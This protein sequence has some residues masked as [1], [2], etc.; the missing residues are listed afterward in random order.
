MK[1]LLIAL[2]CLTLSSVLLASC[3]SGEEHV[4]TFTDEWRYDASGHWHT[5]TCE[6]ADEVSD[7]GAHVDS[8]GNDICDVC[9]YIADHTHTFETAWTQGEDTHYYKSACGHNVKKD[10]AKHKDADNDGDCDVCAYNGGHEH[11]FEEGWTGLEDG[12]WH[13]PACGHT[14]DGIGKEAHADEDNDGAC[15]I[16]AYNGGH[17]HTYAEEFTTTSDEHWREVTCG[18]SIPVGDKGVHADSDGDTACDVCGYIPEH[19]HTFEETW[20]ADANGH[21]HKAT[22]E[23]IDVKEDEAAHSGY[24]AD[25]VCDVCDFVV[26]KLYTVTFDVPYYVTVKGLDGAE[27]ISFAV[28][29]NEELTATVTIPDVAEFISLTGAEAVGEPAVTEEGTVYTVRINA[30]TSDATVS[31]VCNKL[32]AVEIIVGEGKGTLTVEEAF[33]Y[34]YESITFTAPMA[35]RYAIFSTDHPDV[36]FGVGEKGEDGYEIFRQVFTLDVAKAGDVTVKAR[37][38]PWAVPESGTIE[39]TYVVVKVD[40]SL[41]LRDLEGSGYTL[42]TNV[43]VTIRFTAPQKGRYQIS[44]S[45][46]GLAWNDYISDSLMLEATEDGQ[47]LSFTVRY[48]NT[49][50]VSY[51]FDWSIVLM[52]AQALK[53]GDNTVVAPVG[54]YTAVALTAEKAGSYL[55]EVSNPYVRLFLWS[56]TTGSL[57]SQGTSYTTEDLSP[58]D[59]VLLYVSV[60]VYDYEGTEDIEDTLTVSCVGYVPEL[61]NGV[62]LAYVDTPNTFISSAEASDFVLSVPEGAEISTD[63]ASWQTSLR[64]SLDDYG[65]VTYFVRNTD[66]SDTV[67]VTVT[68]IAYEFTLHVGTQTETMVAG[69]D[70][71]VFLAGTSSEEW[72]VSYILNWED[73]DVS[74]MFGSTPINPGDTIVNYSEYYALTI[75][76]SGTET[77]DIEFELLDPAA[78][79]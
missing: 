19:F 29:E 56:E 14:V 2:I 70:Y 11:T 78:A 35:G 42:P 32:S 10:E 6:H 33:K 43:D 55:L 74:V 30:V 9:G 50:A 53:E 41:T 44:S 17:E 72:Y 13:A 79:P 45:T 46:L 69:K 4:H 66:G 8:D 58:G 76:Y 3:D 25:G 1:K 36:P 71:T 31:V 57:V 40:E 52:D 20:S 38:F 24:E 26:F 67:G 65:T 21:W 59:R 22:C 27:G 68:R 63:G 39:Y 49:S 51:Q 64:V 18:H 54:Q 7:K 73:P 37:Y 61:S 28:R 15:D 47:E 60:D 62:Y 5:A 77:A 75:F 12:H 34:A 16:C 48:E 23:H